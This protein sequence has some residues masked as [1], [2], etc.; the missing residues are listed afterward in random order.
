MTLRSFCRYIG[1]IQERLGVVKLETAF[2]D[3]SWSSSVKAKISVVAGRCVVMGL[4][5]I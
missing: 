5:S 2:I 4:F 1:W 3:N